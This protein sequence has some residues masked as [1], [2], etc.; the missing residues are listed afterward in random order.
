MLVGRIIAMPLRI[1][2]PRKM[3]LSIAL[4][5][6]LIFT[7]MGVY[8]VH[9]E[10]NSAETEI[11]E[12]T[13]PTAVH[14][15]QMH[16]KTLPPDF[17]YEYPSISER[18]S[19]VEAINGIERQLGGALYIV[20]DEGN[21]LISGTVGSHREDRF[22]WHDLV[23]DREHKHHG[24]GDGH[25]YYAIAQQIP[26]QS[27]YVVAEASTP[28]LTS[29]SIPLIYLT[30]IG[31]SVSILLVWCTSRSQ[32]RKFQIGLLTQ[33]VTD[34]ATD[35]LNLKG[36][37]LA[38]K[39]CVKEAHVHKS[40]LAALLVTLNSLPKHSN[41]HI[42]RLPTNDILRNMVIELRK[43]IGHSDIVCRSDTDEFILLL[44]HTSETS[45]RAVADKLQEIIGVT[46]FQV[47]GGLATIDISISICTLENQEDLQFFI[48]RLRT[49]L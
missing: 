6:L 19:L 47:P 24:D 18:T 31:M 22:S 33:S 9:H 12:S 42:P 11:R 5:L 27:V 29:H 28:V 14:F 23:D 41:P 30:L 16:L 25:R 40:E 37:N 39:K 20:D 10:F 38:A 26:G 35:A 48:A 13:L 15:L 21:R 45:A 17:D 32:L 36:F 44:K 2:A 4:M 8:I 34:S 7:T 43:Q 3:L 1:T 46:G 49:S